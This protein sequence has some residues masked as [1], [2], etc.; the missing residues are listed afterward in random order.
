MAGG[1]E[2]PTLAEIA[3]AAVPA[4]RCMLTLGSDGGVLRLATHA[5]V[6]TAIT[7]PIPTAILFV[8]NYHPLALHSV[9][10]SECLPVQIRTTQHA[11]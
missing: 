9:M 5:A 4:G 11:V 10:Q 1:Q 7:T 2:F 6:P 3:I 8:I